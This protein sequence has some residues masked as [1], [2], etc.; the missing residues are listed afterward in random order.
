M[1]GNAG[2]LT[3]RTT[4]LVDVIPECVAVI[5]VD[6]V[7]T[8]VASPVDALIVATPALELSQESPDDK[9]TALPSE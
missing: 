3:V 9:F 5:L 4:G 8:A 7:A 1:T 2:G 6:P